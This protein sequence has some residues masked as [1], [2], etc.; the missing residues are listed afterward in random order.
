M[1]WLRPAICDTAAT[2][3]AVEARPSPAMTMGR[4]TIDEAPREPR[5]LRSIQDFDRTASG[6]VKGKFTCGSSR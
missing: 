6:T 3:M 4:R 5:Y 1:V 2:W